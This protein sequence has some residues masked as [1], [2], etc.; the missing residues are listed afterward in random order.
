MQALCCTLERFILTDG[1]LISPADPLSLL[2]SWSLWRPASS[3]AGVKGSSFPGADADSPDA[4]GGGSKPRRPG[5]GK[6]GSDSTGATAGGAAARR[7][8]LALPDHPPAVSTS[9]SSGGG[10]ADSRS[11]S[12]SDGGLGSGRQR[13]RGRKLLGPAELAAAQAAA[14]AD[15]S[16]PTDMVWCSALLLTAAAAQISLGHNT[17]VNATIQV[18][19]LCQQA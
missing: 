11:S 15:I 6:G 18:W 9:S 17:A 14:D 7:R 16:L 4:V 12:S 19:R 10:R 2:P 3:G 5:T 1:K 13:L 8:V